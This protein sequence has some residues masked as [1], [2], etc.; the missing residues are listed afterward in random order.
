M[1]LILLSLKI[2]SLR[3]AKNVRDSFIDTLLIHRL[4]MSYANLN[5][6]SHKKVLLCVLDA[7]K[8]SNLF[9]NILASKQSGLKSHKIKWLQDELNSKLPFGLVSN[10]CTIDIITPEELDLMINSKN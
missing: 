5:N 4:I 8:N 7:S 9:I 1:L 6:V 3:V 10:E 2:L